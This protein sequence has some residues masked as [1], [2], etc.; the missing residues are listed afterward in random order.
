MS[1]NDALVWL[2]TGCS[3]GFGRDIADYLLGQGQRVV[4]T[5]RNTDK[6]ADFAAREGALV[7]ALDVTDRERC[8]AVAAQATQHFGKID[9]L[10]NNAGIGYFAAVEETA[11]SDA[12]RLMEVNFFG[13]ANAID[14]VLP[15]MR[16]R[17]SGAIV[18][19]TSIGGIT[20]FT[21]V[22]YYSASKFALEGLSDTLRK[23]LGPLG[24]KVMTV[25]PGPFRTPFV[26]ACTDTATPIADY[27]STA[28]AARRAY[29]DSAGREAGDPKRAAAA[30]FTAVMAA[31]PPQYL[32]LG[33]ISHDIG[34]GKLDQ[35]HADFLEWEAVAR[36]ADFP[37]Q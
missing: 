30:I 19:L 22:G 21:A 31:K 5:A 34:I 16:Q 26:D 24:I 13:A 27:D 4:V 9:V 3:T 32:L 18:N 33:Q 14:A 25:Q 11:P 10:V 20:G 7:L 23:E 15:G 17:R 6:I 29:R 35:M 36:S 1:E 2:V 28:G 37:A 8:F 12:R